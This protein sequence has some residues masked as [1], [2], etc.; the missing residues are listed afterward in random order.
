MAV[1]KLFGAD[2]ALSPEKRGHVVPRDGV[3]RQRR[4][5]SNSPGSPGGRH[6]TRENP[7]T[8]PGW[9][10][11]REL[12]FLA[13]GEAVPSSGKALERRAA[14]L[15][16][17]GRRKRRRVGTGKLVPGRRDAGSGEDQKAQESN[18]PG[19]PSGGRGVRILAGSKT[20]KLRGIVT[21]WSSEQQ[22]AMS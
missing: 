6:G 17:R 11:S 20:L 15:S 13:R 14:P 19:S 9:K 5:H 12:P 7:R 18:G 1:G 4:D 2:R 3:V 10:T 16:E 22:D 21:S 8:G